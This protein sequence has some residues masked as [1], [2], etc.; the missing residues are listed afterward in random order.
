M[1]K[2]DLDH[3]AEKFVERRPPKHRG[4]IYRK[5]DA[6][7]EDPHPPDSKKLGGY[8]LLRADVGEY[9]ITYRVEE[10][11]L[12]V[13]LGGKRNDDEVYKQLKRLGG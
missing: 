12:K 10:E 7:C 1:L 4:Q 13:Y 3:R 2:L 5:L 6:L 8:A 9:R 11:L